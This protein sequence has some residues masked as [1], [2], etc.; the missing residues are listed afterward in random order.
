MVDYIG[1]VEDQV[2]VIFVVLFVFCLI[3]C[4]FNGYGQQVIE[5]FVCRGILSGVKN[6]V[7]FGLGISVEFVVVV[8]YCIWLVM[9]DF[10]GGFDI[11]FIDGVVQLKIYFYWYLVYVVECCIG[12]LGDNFCCGDGF[13]VVYEGELYQQ[14]EF[15]M[16]EE[17]YYDFGVFVCYC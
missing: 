2:V 10:D 6:V 15:I 1:F 9:I 7:D 17:V 16:V 11:V 8:D 5:K 4:V 12:G 13:S 3:V 14:E